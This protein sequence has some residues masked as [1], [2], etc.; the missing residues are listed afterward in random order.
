MLEL[1]LM[2]AKQK[3]HRKEQGIG[4]VEETGAGEWTAGDRFLD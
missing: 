4:N 1:T 3:W 2:M